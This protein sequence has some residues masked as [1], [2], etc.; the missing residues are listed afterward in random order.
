MET[1]LLEFWRSHNPLNS[2]IA[3]PS[4]VF[5]HPRKSLS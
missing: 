1:H 2:D 3:K 4:P 5:Q